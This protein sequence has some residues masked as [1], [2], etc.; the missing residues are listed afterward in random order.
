MTYTVSTS[1]RFLRRAKRF[2]RAHPELRERFTSLVDALQH[3]PLQPR[4][5]LHPLTGELAGLYAVSLTHSYRVTLTLEIT[6]QAITLFDIG[7]HDEVYR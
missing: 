5:R 7:S 1:P 6:E 2:F 4:L 3:D